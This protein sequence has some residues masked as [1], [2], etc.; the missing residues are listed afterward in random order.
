MRSLLFPFFL[1]AMLVP[2]VGADSVWQDGDATGPLVGG[3]DAQLQGTFV[4]VSRSA[5]QLNI[6]VGARTI[7]IHRALEAPAVTGPLAD[8]GDVQVHD[9][10]YQWVHVQGG[11]TMDATV[12]EPIARGLRVDG[13]YLVARDLDW[14]HDGALLTID[15]T[16]TLIS[17]DGGFQNLGPEPRAWVLLQA[18]DDGTVMD[19]FAFSGAPF[20]TRSVADEVVMDLVGTLGDGAP[21]VLVR[22]EQEGHFEP[23]A[24]RFV[25][26]AGS[27]AAR[28]VV[29]DDMLSERGAFSFHA[30]DAGHQIIDLRLPEG[31]SGEVRWSQDL[32]APTLQALDVHNIDPYVPLQASPEM[33]LVFDEPVLGELHIGSQTK[34][35]LQPAYEV[36]FRLTGLQPETAYQ[37]TVDARDLAGNTLTIDGNLTTGPRAGPG[38]AIDIVDVDDATRTIRFT[39]RYDDGTLPRAEQFNVLIDK[40]PQLGIVRNVGE[41]FALAYPEGADQVVIELNTVH[42]RVSATHAFEPPQQGAPGPA[43][44]LVLAALVVAARR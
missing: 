2:V 44:A 35:T 19:W 14:S 43:I 8:F 31:L 12:V 22:F 3:F 37:Y 11:F 23:R 9:N 27:L 38:A 6:D 1:L 42:G 20:G 16:D 24:D 28:T 10:V 29:A 13:A 18:D 15:A 39:A 17:N 21:D 4:Q 30:R 41:M 36:K 40:R 32:Q 5:D 7:T 26:M 25:L 33:L 34:Q